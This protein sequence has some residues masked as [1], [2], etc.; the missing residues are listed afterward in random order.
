MDCLFC[1]ILNGDIP[2]DIIYEDEQV[3][4]FNDVNPQ[5]PQHKLII[6]RQHIATLNDL[7][8]EHNALLGHMMNIA[9][10]IAEKL[11]IADDGYRVL[12]NCNAGA[13]QTVFH[14]HLHLLGGRPL[15]WPPG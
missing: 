13:G 3:I 10:K 8:E 5:A 1:K 14:I 12:M 6:P 7:H 15:L 11:N 2:A 9:K 4:A